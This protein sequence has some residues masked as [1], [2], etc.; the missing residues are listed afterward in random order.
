MGDQHEH[1]LI[2]KVNVGDDVKGK[3]R[4]LKRYEIFMCAT[5]ESQQKTRLLNLYVDRVECIKGMSRTLRIYFPYGGRSKGHRK[6]TYGS[7]KPSEIL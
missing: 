1:P 5:S 6:S 4:Y 7:C 3:S 2:G